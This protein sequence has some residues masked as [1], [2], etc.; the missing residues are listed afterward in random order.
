M[1]LF[2]VLP[3]TTV[4]CS[5]PSG[6]EEGPGSITISVSGAD[7]VVGGAPRQEAS[8]VFQ[9]V[10]LADETTPRGLVRVFGIAAVVVLGLGLLIM[11]VRVW[12]LRALVT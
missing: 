6:H 1:L 5:L 8:G 11:F 3:M 2:L 7:V 9:P 10:D 12:R 4:S